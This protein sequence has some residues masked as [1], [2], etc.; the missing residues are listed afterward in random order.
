MER[1]REEDGVDE[2]NARGKREAKIWEP[3]SGRHDGMMTDSLGLN[4]AIY[5][6]VSE[7]KGKIYK[8][9]NLR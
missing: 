8:S 9:K 6:F 5:E 3:F 1:M 7:T 2:V 4:I